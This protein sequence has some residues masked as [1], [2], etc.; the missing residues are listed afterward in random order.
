MQKGV[1]V[2]V[3]EDAIEEDNLDEL[4]EKAR[5]KLEKEYIKKTE[6]SSSNGKVTPYT[7]TVGRPLRST[8]AAGQ[9]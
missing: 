5:E 4:V 6:G 7:F 8:G 3:T 1:Q 2:D 9:G